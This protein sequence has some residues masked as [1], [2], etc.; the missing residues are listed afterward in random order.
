MNQESDTRREEKNKMDVIATI[1]ELRIITNNHY[2][3]GRLNEAIK[4]SETIIALAR[5]S[6][7][8]SV[9][10]EQIQ[11]VQSIYSKMERDKIFIQI[12]EE[13]NSLKSDF[14]NLIKNNDI[15]SAHKR[16]EAF[17]LKYEKNF[18]FKD[19]AEIFEL[20]SDENKHWK[21]YLEIQ[22]EIIR[23][24]ESLEIQLESYLTTDNIL[25]A[26][27]ALKNAEELRK[28]LDDADL[29]TRWETLEA[30]YLELRK[31]HNINEEIETGM[32][33]VSA[34]TDDYQYK[35]ALNLI[36]SMIMRAEKEDLAEIKQNLE[37]KKRATIDAEKKYKSLLEEISELDLIVKQ[38]LSLNQFNEAISNLE[39]IIKISRFIGKDEYVQNCTLLIG[40]IETKIKL[41][42]RYDGV[43][44]QVQ[45]LNDEGLLALTQK[46]FSKALEIFKTIH[47]ILRDY[48][49]GG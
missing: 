8:D 23:K 34:L 6:D 14:E 45:E 46:K 42:N 33:E 37:N 2:I 28:N 3:M 7:L 5:K 24:L 10:N 20:L 16:V 12:K 40:E 26:E 36:D 18:D 11:F 1:D 29:I 41:L 4:T 22:G 9:A 39:Q 48:T 25:L 35:E 21:H 30:M 44:E 27:E 31:R 47:K 17:R 49:Q 15:V 43:K 19:N 38:N 13:F 32:E